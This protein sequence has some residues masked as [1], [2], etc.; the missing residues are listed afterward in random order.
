MGHSITMTKITCTKTGKE[1][2]VEEVQEG[3]DNTTFVC[4]EAQDKIN[5]PAF[6]KE[7]D[8]LKGKDERTESEDVR[9]KF[10]E[11]KI[12]SISTEETEE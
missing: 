10:L 12:A 3:Q 4:R 8:D 9:I 6:E 11:D 2:E 5:L 1:V 7:L